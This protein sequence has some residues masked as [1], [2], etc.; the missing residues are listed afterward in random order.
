MSG[1]I[2]A[3]P[4]TTAGVF[5]APGGA[6]GAC[7][8]ETQ[9][10]GTIAAGLAAVVSSAGVKNTIYL[11][12]GTYTE[13]VTIPSGLTITIQGGWLDTGGTWTPQ[14]VANPQA[15]AVIQAPPGTNSTIVASSGQTTLETLTVKSA[16]AAA[17]QS[18]YGLMLT[19]SSTSVTLNQVDVNITAGGAGSAGSTG[20]PGT[21]GAA[22]TCPAISD[23]A[24]GGNGQPGAGAGAGSFGA[25]GYTPTSGAAGVSAGGNG[26]NGTAGAM[27]AS[28]TITDPCYDDGTGAGCSTITDTCTGGQGTCGNAGTGSGPGGAGTG[29]GSSV[30]VYVWGATL[31][32]TGGS[33]IE[34]GNGG[35]GGDGGPGGT[36]GAG[37]RG[38]TGVAGKYGTACHNKLVGTSSICL[39]TTSATC[40]AG[41]LGSVGGSGGQG[42]HGGGGSGGSSFCWYI[43]AGG[44]V[45]SPSVT[46]TNGSTGLGGSQGFGVSQGA[47]G[48]SGTHN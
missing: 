10:C 43:G 4:D 48:G 19:G 25:G 29:G 20:S 42:G 5:V 9:P 36:P 31:N 1:C 33:T 39:I 14:C 28:N 24:S 47:N 32:L 35:S 13:Q 11:A 40:A 15:G 12:N 34:T 23:G 30:G 26:D 37:A 22:G 17:G 18:L 3:Q 44:V 27:G 46:C 8:S 41:G 45:N 2:V 16:T 6:G 38:L 7:G 21:N